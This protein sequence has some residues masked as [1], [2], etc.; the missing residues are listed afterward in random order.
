MGFHEQLGFN[1]AVALE[2]AGI[3]H[4]VNLS[5]IGAHLPMG[6][7]LPSGLHKVE[8]ILNSSS[9]HIRH[10]R[11]GYFYLNLFSNIGLIKQLGIMG[12]N[13]SADPN[14]L[15]IAAPADIAT[16]AAEELLLLTFKGHSILYVTSDET[17]TNEIATTIGSAIGKKDLL[18]MQMEDEQVL[19]ALL[20]FGVS[21]DAAHHIVQTGS[22][23]DKGIL[24]E[25]YHMHRPAKLGAVRLNDFANQFANAYH[26]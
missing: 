10:L 23:I 16:A 20:Q 21:K 26:G 15:P 8:K 17:G 19:N 4:V 5:S 25:D 2:N 12:S 14:S 11:A 3:K 1:Y 9:A 24:M 22:A 18:W 13:F 7:G 6:G